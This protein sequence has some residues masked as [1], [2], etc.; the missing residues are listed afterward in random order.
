MEILT[1][2]R[3]DFLP[4]LGALMPCAGPVSV[5]TREGGTTVSV[6]SFVGI[7]VSGVP[8]AAKASFSLGCLSGPGDYSHLTHKGIKVW[9]G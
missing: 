4:R 9:A 2:T 3:Q 6:G 5:K 1:W 7:H 8:A